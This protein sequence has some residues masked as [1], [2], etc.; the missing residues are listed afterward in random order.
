M[1]DY[2]RAVVFVLVLGGLTFAVTIKPLSV[3]A[4]RQRILAWCGIWLALTVSFFLARNFWLILPVS[5]VILL[6]SM[7][8]EDDKT[9]LY[10]LAF[11]MAPVVVITM[12][13]FGGLNNLVAFTFQDFL[14][15][16]LLVP[17]LLSTS[18]TKS[19]FGNAARSHA[20]CLFCPCFHSHLSGNNSYQHFA[21]VLRLGLSML[22]PFLAFSTL[23]NTEGKMRGAIHAMIF[24]AVSLALVGVFEFVKH[25]HVYDP[26]FASWAN[27]SYLL[28]GGQLRAFGP[29]LDPITFGTVFM[30]GIGLCL[31]I[32]KK[33]LSTGQRAILVA[34]LVGGLIS[35]F[36]RGP[37]LGT[38]VILVVFL[39]TGPNPVGSLLKFTTMG[40]AAIFLLIMTPIGDRIINLLPYVG[41][42][43]NTVTAEYRTKLLENAWIVIQRNPVFGS[44]DYLQT[45]E[46]QEMIQGQGIIDIV[47]TYLQVA[48]NAGFVGLGLFVLFFAA[49]LAGLA[50]AFMALAGIRFR[51]KLMARALFATLCGLLVTIFTVSSV[52]HIPYFYW[53]LAGLCVAQTRIIRAHIA[54][55]RL[56][57]SA[58]AP[59]ESPF[60]AQP[61]PV[62]APTSP[63]AALQAAGGFSVVDAPPLTGLRARIVN[64]GMW[65]VTGHVVENLIRLGTSLVM[66]RL[67]VPGDF[68]LMAV[69]LTIPA[70][71][72]DAVGFG[73][74][75]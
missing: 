3:L 8:W 62:G 50:R 27:A 51:L 14:A 31:A 2:I 29:M 33:L 15:L 73:H 1:P 55:A 66:T 63:S 35:P 54:A 7:K 65:T 11:C 53:I 41:S 32:P 18:G 13:G 5:A 23:V 24:A 16:L 43:E 25:W 26:A 64:A 22:V 40:A 46:M 21:H 70:S 34:L 74:P 71:L 38:V 9:V 42:E 39:L 20:F 67:L 28:R 12:P 56:E 72:A 4:G 19:R 61:D 69:A 17:A 60:P 45:P 10:L 36:S 47:N 44:V 75:Q 52:G 57:A 37:W 48:L 58:T 68:G 6:I 30:V 49:V 59:P